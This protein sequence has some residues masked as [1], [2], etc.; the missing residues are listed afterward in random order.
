MYTKIKLF[1]IVCSSVCLSAC[2]LNGENSNTSYYSPNNE[3]QTT[4]YPEGYETMGNYDHPPM[5][6]RDTTEVI[7]PQTYHINNASTSPTLAKDIDKNWVSNQ[8]PE[9]YTIEIASDNKPATVANILYKAPKTEH[10]AEV[11]VKNG[12][13][14]GLYG[15]YNSISAAQQTLNALPENIRQGATIKTWGSV[16]TN[17][18]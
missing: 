6:Q 12:Q 16:Q 18:N 7:V 17:L 13:Y 9:S 2:M 1:S 4:L 3:Q 11:Q 14:E 5:L 8:N 15:T 10:T